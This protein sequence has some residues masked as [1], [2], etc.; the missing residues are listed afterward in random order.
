MDS[1]KKTTTEDFSLINR[2]NDQRRSSSL[3]KKIENAL[4]RQSKRISLVRNK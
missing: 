1:S 4:R 2:C 3:N